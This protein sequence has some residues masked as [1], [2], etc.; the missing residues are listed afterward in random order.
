MF[1]DIKIGSYFLEYDDARSGTFAPLRFVPKGKF[2]VLGLVSS[3]RPELEPADLLRR[4]I[5]EASRHVNLD[6]L[7]LSPQCGFSTSATD[8]GAMTEEIEAA[9]LRRVV[10]VA[11]EVWGEA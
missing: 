6:Q 1:N 7:G 4:R 3:K 11:R 5:E 2:V 9:K 10:E 8:R